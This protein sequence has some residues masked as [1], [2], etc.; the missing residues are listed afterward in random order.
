M[1]FGSEVGTGHV[2]IFPSM[3]GFRSAVDKEMR[4][5]GKSGSN[6][7]S[8]AFGNGS[9]IGKSFGG[10]FKKAFGSS[11]RGVADDVLKPLK[12]DAA[13]A[14]SKASAALLNYRQATVNV[15]QAQERLNSAIARYGSDSTQAQTA[16][17]NLEKASCVRPPLSTIPT[18]PPNGSR[19]RR[20]RSKPP[21]T[22]SPRAPTPYPV[23]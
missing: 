1:A 15:Q 20:R 7:F 3:K 9:K 10:S 16:S 5:A 2:S 13:Q 4:G 14:S 22:N 6:R 18:T 11:A 19:T 21:R 23:P 12:R 17:I 8:Q